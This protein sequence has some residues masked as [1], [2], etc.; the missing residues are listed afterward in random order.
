MYKP[1]LLFLVLLLSFL[2]GLTCGCDDPD[3]TYQPM[4]SKFTESPARE[5]MINMAL[6]E[7]GIADPYYHKPDELVI[8]DDVGIIGIEVDGTF[9]AFLK[10]GMMEMDQ[11]VVYANK[12]GQRLTIVYC[13]HTD[14]AR[15]FVPGEVADTEIL[16][17]GMWENQ[18]ALMVQVRFARSKRRGS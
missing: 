4:P 2:L 10:Q 16:M 3:S 18:M 13:N 7:P 9:R 1:L 8:P 15:V 12:N 14:C 17:G 6:E 11:H 5:E